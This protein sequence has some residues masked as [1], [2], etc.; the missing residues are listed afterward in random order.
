MRVEKELANMFSD[1]INSLKLL[2][3]VDDGLT[4]LGYAAII[5]TMN[6][7]VIDDRYGNRKE[8]ASDI[9]ELC[10]MKL[11]KAASTAKAKEDDIKK[12]NVIDNS[13]IDNEL[14]RWKDLAS[15]YMRGDAVSIQRGID[16]LYAKTVDSILFGERTEEA[17]NTKDIII[18]EMQAKLD[19]INLPIVSEESDE[20]DQDSCDSNVN[21]EI[22]SIISEILGCELSSS[23]LVVDSMVDGKLSD[24]VTIN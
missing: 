16:G 19:G 11:E 6:Q 22:A 5:H 21:I 10:L 7:Q 17:K 24:L 12:P 14:K 20:S 23:I 8:E 1:E 18:L 13:A 15:D 2:A 4:S 3:K 9:K